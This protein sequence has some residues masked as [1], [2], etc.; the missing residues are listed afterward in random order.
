MERLKVVVDEVRGMLEDAVRER[1]RAVREREEAVKDMEEAVRKM[2]QL[3]D[4]VEAEK[5]KVSSIVPPWQP[6][7]CLPGS[8]AAVLQQKCRHIPFSLA[9]QPK[10][11]QWCR[12]FVGDGFLQ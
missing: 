12:I 7:S 1:E 11:R 3:E 10:C 8:T 4:E 2:E 9:V 6:N 5:A